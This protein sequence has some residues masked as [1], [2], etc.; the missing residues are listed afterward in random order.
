MNQLTLKRIVAE[1]EHDPA[2]D[3]TGLLSTE[4]K[5][6]PGFVEFMAQSIRTRGPDHQEEGS[7]DGQGPPNRSRIRLR[8]VGASRRDTAPAE[9]WST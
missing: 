2:A 4:Q 3:L 1:V 6:Y 5:R 8:L 9:R 7:V